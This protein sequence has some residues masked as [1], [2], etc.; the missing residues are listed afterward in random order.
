[1]HKN[2]KF[3]LLALAYLGVILAANWAL[4]T[5]GMISIGFGLMAPAGV[6][7]AGLSFG[8]R[9][10]LQE[11]HGRLSTITLIF[12]GAGLSW[13]ISPTFALASGIA[14]LFGELA[15]LAVYTPLRQKQW[16]TAVIASNIVGSIIDSILFLLLAFGTEELTWQGLAGLTLGKFYMIIPSIFIVKYYRNQ[17]ND[18]LRQSV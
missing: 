18:L 13:F 15:D 6:F 5:W 14:F 1:M 10:A 2:L 11:S 3:I 8:L 12:I 17:T 9:D 7:F 4:V 16:T